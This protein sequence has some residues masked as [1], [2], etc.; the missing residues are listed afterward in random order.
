M[1]FGE[2][3]MVQIGRL[4]EKPSLKR[5]GDGSVVSNARLI[6]NVGWKDKGTGDLKDR[7]EGFNYELWGDSAQRFAELEAGDEVYVRGEPRNYS[8]EPGD[9]Q[10]TRYGV[11]IVI[12]NWRAFN[13]KLK[14]NG[15]AGPGGGGGA[16]DDGP[17]F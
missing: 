11:R 15:D 9:G 6:T 5:N 16:D 17:A 10:P 2:L 3:M 12:S 8:W 13:K 14:G 1:V 7:A 4:A